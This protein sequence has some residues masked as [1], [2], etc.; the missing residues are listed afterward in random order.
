MWACMY[1]CVESTGACHECGGPV[2]ALPGRIN[3]RGKDSLLEWAAPPPRQPRYEEVGGEGS[4][5]CLSPPCWRRHL[6]CCSCHHSVLTSE[7]SFLSLSGEP[8]ASSSPRILQAFRTTKV[9]TSQTEQLLASQ[10][11]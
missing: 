1:T 6:L 9:P 5:A 3:Q 2:R 10:P 8:K 11:L 4:A 7:H